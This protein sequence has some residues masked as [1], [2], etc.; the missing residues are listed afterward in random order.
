[1]RGT[2]NRR[3]SEFLFS[4]REALRSTRSHWRPL[5]P[6]TSSAAATGRRTGL[7]PD[8]VR[9][10][11]AGKPVLIRNPHAI[12]P[13]QHVLEPLAG[14]LGLANRLLS[15]EADFA[16][17][18]NFGP[19]EEDA[20]PV[21]RIADA[22]TRAWGGTSSWVRDGAENPHEAGYLKLDASKAR[23]LLHWKP[24]LPLEGALN[25]LVEWF[26][27]W[28]GQADMQDFTLGQIQEYERLLER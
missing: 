21:G 24:V 3:L 22:M 5:A 26:L 6:A 18:W 10:F 15:A 17:G 12:R 16:G 13:W 23:T 20:W 7:I 2:R 14:Y 8:L 28:Q 4:G 9:G 27:A 19:S 11:L 1:M 25:W